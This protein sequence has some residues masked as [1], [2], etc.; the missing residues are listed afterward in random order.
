[1][2]NTVDINPDTVARLNY[3]FSL[4]KE[5]RTISV[6]EIF[7]R[8]NREFLLEEF[9][10]RDERLLARIELFMRQTAPENRGIPRNTLV[11]RNADL[12]GIR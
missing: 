4:P 11:S 8:L 12:G 9:V 2:E 6:D 5:C 7:D 10:E 1:M 3:F